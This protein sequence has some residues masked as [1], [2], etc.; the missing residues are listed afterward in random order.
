MASAIAAQKGICF[1]GFQSGDQSERKKWLLVHKEAGRQI[2]PETAELTW[3]FAQTQDPYG[4]D[5]ELPEEY[6]QV[7]REY[8]A[9]CP[10]K[11]HLGSDSR[12]NNRYPSC[13]AGKV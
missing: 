4:I 3:I 10:G 1:A 9:R 2:D 5:P 12:S 13:L 11:P 6:Q 7:G 8:F